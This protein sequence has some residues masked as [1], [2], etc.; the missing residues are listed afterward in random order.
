MHEFICVVSQ[1]NRVMVNL[2]LN[3]EESFDKTVVKKEIKVT[4]FVDDEF[5]KICVEDNGPG[6]SEKM[7]KSA[8]EAYVT[9]KSNG[10]GLG[11]GKKY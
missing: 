1:I 3:S 2:M 6:F 8:K 11:L 5:V 4:L 9:T 10:T 7:L